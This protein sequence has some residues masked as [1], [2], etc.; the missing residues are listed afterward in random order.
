MLAPV[1]TPVRSWF[2][3][4]TS[5]SATAAVS[6][7]RWRWAQL[8]QREAQLRKRKNLRGRENAI[9]ANCQTQSTRIAG[10]VE[11]FG[12]HAGEDD[13]VVEV[14]SGAHG[15]IWRWPDGRRYGL[16]PLASFYRTEF[17]FLQDGP[18]ESVTAQGEA[19]PFED[20]SVY[21]LLSDNVLDHAQDPAQLLAECRR[22]IRDDGALY[23]TF[24]VH[25][26]VWGLGARIYNRIA[27]TGLRLR[28]PAF[29]NHPFHF[30]EET[31]D[32]LLERSGWNVVWRDRG[33]PHRRLG[34]PRDI[35]KFL[36]E[37]DRRVS[38][39]ACPA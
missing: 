23:L 38:V 18:V 26:P 6:D 14:G 8:G 13:V 3:A 30:R 31:V 16:D 19:M 22:V 39:L 4:A 12:F 34:A 28:V 24:D 5:G 11:G 7:R 25:H 15:L 1:R 32:L 29:P 10:F 35:V 21:L 33:V 2:G 36:F 20:A 27:D 9:F 37:K 17:A